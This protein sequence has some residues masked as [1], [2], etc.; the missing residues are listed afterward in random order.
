MAAGK[1]GSSALF[2]AM[3]AALAGVAFCLGDVFAQWAMAFMDD[4]A[5]SSGLF[6]TWL[7]AREAYPPLGLCLEGNALYGGLAAAAATLLAAMASHDSQSANLVDAASVH[8]GARFATAA[9]MALYAHE[10][11]RGR[12]P[13]ATRR[14][15]LRYRKIDWRRPEWCDDVRD[16]NYVLSRN[17]RISISENPDRI[18]ERNKHVFVMAG[19]GA[20]KT[21]NFVQSNVLNMGSSM[22]FTDPKGEILA[23]N[24]NFLASHGYNIKV[25]NVKDEESFRA[26]NHY[27]PYHYA[28]NSTDLAQIIELLMKNTSGEGGSDS[29]NSGYF[30][31]AERQLYQ[32]LSG[33][34]FYL[35]RGQERTDGQ[36]G[37]LCTLPYII[38][39]LT[40]LKAERDARGNPQDSMLDMAFF[41]TTEE[42]GYQGFKERF[43][44]RYGSER[45][46]RQ[47][48][49]WT[50]IT[51]YEGF[52]T[53][54]DAPETI[55]S[56]ISS[57]F[58]R[59][60]PFTIKSVSSMFAYDDLELETVGSERTALFIVTSAMSGTYDFIA[61]MLLYQLFDVLTRVAESLPGRH[62]PIPVVCYLDE[63]AN[64]GKIPNLARN[65]AFLRSYWVNLVIIVQS[66]ND[67]ERAYSKEEARSIR[68][69]CAITV[70]LGRNDIES[71]EKLSKEIGD[72]TKA[73]ESWSSS[74][75]STGRSVSKSLQYVKEPL[76]SA[77][78]IANGMDGSKCLVHIVQEHWFLDEK[79]NPREHRR[80]GELAATEPFDLQRWAAE[81]E[82]AEAA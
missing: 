6:E 14:G 26:S 29:K 62:L 60:A 70:Y 16:D 55:A 28:K 69:N 56:I 20:G 79:A 68:N 10:G 7:A 23:R 42:D 37:E 9:E 39:Q 61:A 64:I 81:R 43:I 21:Y 44:A 71:C 22:V 31:K 1:G 59:L 30:E 80:W 53:T 34:L 5:G 27:N 72:T 48:D 17:A 46:A 52:K 25:V 40:M 47:H 11:E 45:E 73:Y 57:C 19:S 38:D 3:V 18:H 8:G 51:N 13:V 76:M 65:V 78:D 82:R 75:S 41:A 58:V 12:E 49:E 54:A 66:E 24:G 2:W 15:G 4:A 74:D 50:A 63:V 33:Y 32:A 35:Y 77:D 36:Q 67:L